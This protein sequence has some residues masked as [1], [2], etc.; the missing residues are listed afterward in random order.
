MRVQDVIKTKGAAVITVADTIR[1]DQA[2]RVMQE[3]A[4]GALVVVA[5]DGRLRG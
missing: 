1:V 5:S 4:I 3:Q 2:V